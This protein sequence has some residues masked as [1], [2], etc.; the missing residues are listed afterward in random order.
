[1]HHNSDLF[2]CYYLKK[3]GQ[4][5]TYSINMHGKLH[6]NVKWLKMYSHLYLESRAC[7]SATTYLYV[8]VVKTQTFVFTTHLSMLNLRLIMMS[9]TPA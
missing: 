7:Y 9:T 2:L 3:N 1:M 8:K 4:F 5:H 6:H